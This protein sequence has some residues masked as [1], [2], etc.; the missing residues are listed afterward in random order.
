MKR[1]VILLAVLLGCL[2]QARAGADPVREAAAGHSG[3]E[4]GAGGLPNIKEFLLE[5]LQ[6]SYHWH[7]VT[8]RGRP[9]AIPLPVI[10]VSRGGVEVFSSAHLTHGGEYRGYRIAEAGARK[11]KIVDAAGDR[12]FDVSITRNALALMINSGLMLWI[13]LALRR[14]YRRRGMQ[15]PRGMFGAVEATVKMI[16]EDVIEPCVGH[17]CRRYSPYLLTVFFFILINNLMGLVPFFPGGANTTGNIAVTFAL[18]FC[19]FLM[20]NIFGSRHYWKDIFW[21]DMPLPLKAPVPIIPA[22]EFIG[23]F[24]R[25]FALMIRLFANVLGGH[26]IA[27]GM[28]M[29]IFV[30]HATMSVAGSSS[31]TALFVI[32]GVFMSFIEILVAFIQAYVFTMLSAVFIGMSRAGGEH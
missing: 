18:A 26:S 19:T 13:F 30:V 31:I 22:I 28:V 27:V 7:I 4:H 12:P 25:P 16:E 32:V 23:I 3:G 21:P 2:P 24:T 10:I 20:V 11:G 6:D 5:H 1:L 29:L 15:P 8:W 17:D 14:W 9:V